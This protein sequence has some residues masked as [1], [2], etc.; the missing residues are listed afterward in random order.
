MRHGSELPT[1][2]PN[3]SDADK[4]DHL[5]KQKAG[6]VRSTSRILKSVASMAYYLLGREE[7]WARIFT[8]LMVFACA[9][10]GTDKDLQE[11]PGDMPGM[12]TS[13]SARVVPLAMAC[14]QNLASYCRSVTG[15]PYTSRAWRRGLGCSRRL[16][17]GGCFQTDKARKSAI[18]SNSGMSRDPVAASKA[19]SCVPTANTAAL[20]ERTWAAVL[21]HCCLQSR[22]SKYTQTRI[23][24]EYTH[25]GSVLRV[26][27]TAIQ[28]I[29]YR[30]AFR[31]N[32]TNPV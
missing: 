9:W 10:R 24:T 27:G 18:P 2:Y 3:G 30:R 11:A 5:D 28:F 7:Q 8:E 1:R 29:R 22:R 12:A 17:V 23:S 16:G 14:N 19:G 6:E 20:K 13:N 26:A 15:F 4:W 25:I 31:A 21:G 32:R